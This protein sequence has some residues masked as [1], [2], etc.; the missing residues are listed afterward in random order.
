[1]SIKLNDV[2][3]SAYPLTSEVDWL[4]QRGHTG[5]LNEMWMQEFAAGDDVSFNDA[6]MGWLGGQGYTGTLDERWHQ[7]WGGGEPE[8]AQ[9]TIGSAGGTAAGVALGM[10]RSVA[11]V[12]QG[13]ITPLSWGGSDMIGLNVNTDNNNIDLYMVDSSQQ[14]GA[15]A[16]VDFGAGGTYVLPWVSGESRY[17]IVDVAQ[18][19]AIWTFFN[20][21]F[22]TIVPLEIS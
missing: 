10:H 7:F 5:T 11:W 22:G 3:K 21:N 19:D 1:M 18:S 12:A 4:L 6:A 14:F 8:P 9:F 2:K 17:K 13:D 16:I 20:A 15:S